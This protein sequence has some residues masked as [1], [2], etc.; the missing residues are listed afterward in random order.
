MNRGN[1]I[2]GDAGNMDSAREAEAAWGYRV[3]DLYVNQL[4]NT[5]RVPGK[6]PMNPTILQLCDSVQ[7]ACFLA[8]H[9]AVCSN[10]LLG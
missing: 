10:Q 5:A 8:M 3:R 4:I 6:L 7:L 2:V 1:F 9:R